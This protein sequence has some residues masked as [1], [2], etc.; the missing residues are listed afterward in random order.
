MSIKRVAEELT[1]EEYWERYSSS[2]DNPKDAARRAWI[3]AVNQERR[4]QIVKKQPEP[5]DVEGCKK[6]GVIHYCDDHDV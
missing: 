4:L 6:A 5:C 1:F 2:K 3:A